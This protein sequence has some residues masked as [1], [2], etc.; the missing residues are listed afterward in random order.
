MRVKLNKTKIQ[1]ARNL[2]TLAPQPEPLLK[3]TKLSKQ[4]S[5][6]I[7]NIIEDNR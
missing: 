7:M 3:L 1:S 5:Q 4:I 2:I 6:H